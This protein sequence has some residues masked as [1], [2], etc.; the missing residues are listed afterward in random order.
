[1]KKINLPKLKLPKLNFKR[2]SVG[3]V[4]F[5]VIAIGLSV[6]ASIFAR[7][8][9]A[10][11][12]I[13]SLPGVA[14]ASCGGAASTGPVF[15]PQGT[16]IAT[17]VAT[18][19][20]VSAPVNVAPTWD[21][22]SRVNVLFI[23]V[24]ARDWISN[25]TAP[26]SD[27]MILFT[28]DPISNTAGMI[29]IPR[30]MWVNIPGFGYGRI[31]EAY[32]L[33]EAYKMPGGGPGLAMKTVEQ[34]LGVPVN[35]FGQ[36]DFNT[37]IA[38]IDTIGG[39]D[40]QVKERLV[41]DPVG[42]GMDKVVITPGDRHLVGW[43]ALA[44]ARTR[45]TEGGDVD[46]AQRQ[47]DVIFAIM[48]KVLSPNYFPTFVK[49]ASGLYELMASGIHTNLSFDDGLRL[50]VLLQGIPRENIKTGVI[51]YDMVTMS[52]TILDG[53]SASVFK[54]KP[55]DIRILRDEIF[56]GGAVG[57]LASTG[58]PVQLSK[59]ENARIRVSNGAYA[60]DFGQRTSTYLQGLGLNVTE[61]TSGGP[62]D[63]TVIILYSPKL[64]TMRFL[65]YLFGMNGSSGT[66][67]IR[68]DPNPASPVDLEIRLGNDVA[69]AN[70]VP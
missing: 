48:N 57:A 22:G 58:D 12:T 56:G 28:I 63:R 46:R 38:M 64:Y 35:Y 29:S 69:N 62:Y 42:T 13:T 65:L 30:D 21:R 40:L 49:Q 9:L 50:A 36:V 44:Y 24:D 5:W 26:R 32:S 59:Q 67:Q 33:G 51:N 60:P 20:V 68:F 17:S 39:I 53:Q 52:T 54:P 14:P 61:L 31:N 70:I 66:A 47:Q 11:W 15:N 27:T 43:K 34:F 10:C 25:A 23:G 37:F 19:P 1:M 7:S 55:D 6:T 4:I 16:E 2:P 8:F 18:T 45:K 3:G 41:L